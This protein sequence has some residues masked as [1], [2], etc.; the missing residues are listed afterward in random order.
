[1]SHPHQRDA[2]TLIEILVV[3]SILGVLATLVAPRLSGTI[4]HSKDTLN[5]SQMQ[6]IKRA[7][8]QFYEDVGFVPDT[9][10]LLIYP[11]ESCEVG[12]TNALDSD[13]D[14]R[15]CKRMIAFLDGHYK[16]TDS[17]P[18]LRDGSSDEGDSGAGTRRLSKLID[19]IEQKLD[20]KRGGWR[21]EY[22]GGN[23]V[24]GQEHIKKLGD[25]SDEEENLYYLS[26][27]D[28]QHY[29]SAGVS[30]TTPLYE[31]NPHWDAPHANRELYVIASSD[32][33]GS[34]NL[35]SSGRVI[36]MDA[37]YQNA[38]YRHNLIGA[39]TIIDPYGTPYELQIPTKSS[40]G[41]QNRTNYARIVSFGANRRRDT[42]ID[43]LAI[44]YDAKGYDDSVL[45]LFDGNHTN[46]F[47]QE[48]E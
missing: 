26:D 40:V 29:Y 6:H 4:Q 27:L 5:H 24:L 1:M 12:V 44:D 16:F 35:Q 41:N 3:I 8:L 13:S 45:Y 17:N 22:L 15:T 11:F 34:Q 2:F 33:N 43:R 9:L 21:G 14:S 18:A 37:L 42:Q 25:G 39:M 7:T 20:P 48:V 23:G 36:E 38:K 30:A 31:V 46:Y 28:L 32:F 19:P 47:H 10:S